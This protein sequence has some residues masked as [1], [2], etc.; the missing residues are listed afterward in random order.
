WHAVVVPLGLGLLAALASGTVAYA[1]WRTWQRQP[2]RLT[3]AKRVDQSCGL[4]GM[5]LTIVAEAHR[6]S[7]A[8]AEPARERQQ[9]FLAL[10]RDRVWREMERERDWPPFGPPVRRWSHG[11]AAV[12]VLAAV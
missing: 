11:W 2:D 7:A 6:P 5:L 3:V 10:V 12:A 4:C 8:S 9:A 1:L